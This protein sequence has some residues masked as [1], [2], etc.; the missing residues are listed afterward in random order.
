MP[1]T[2]INLLFSLS[3]PTEKTSFIPFKQ[4]REN[5]Y[6]KRKEKNGNKKGNGTPERFIKCSRKRRKSFS[7]YPKHYHS[8]KQADE[9]LEAESEQHLFQMSSDSFKNY[10]AHQY[11]TLENWV[12]LN[13]KRPKYK[14]AQLQGSCC[15]SHTTKPICLHKSLYCKDP[16]SHYCCKD[17]KSSPN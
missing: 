8:V 9:D 15:F 14:Q 16:D 4:T 2:Y 17:D 10:T 6:Q 1:R 5:K 3:I 7:N 13:V 12:V 11:T